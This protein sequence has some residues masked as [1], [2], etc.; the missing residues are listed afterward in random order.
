MPCPVS[1]ALLLVFAFFFA[2]IEDWAETRYK[3]FFDGVK[4]AAERP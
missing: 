3:R 2:G 4:V 1:G